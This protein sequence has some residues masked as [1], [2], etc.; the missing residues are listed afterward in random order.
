MTRP[1]PAGPPAPVTTAVR[2]SGNPG[3]TVDG[4]A[5]GADVIGIPSLQ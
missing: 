4:A 3:K 2:G 5:A 1:I